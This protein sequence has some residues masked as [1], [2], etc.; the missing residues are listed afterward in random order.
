MADVL[1]YLLLQENNKLPLL[2]NAN[3]EKAGK[4]LN[5]MLEEVETEME[6]IQIEKDRVKRVNGITVG[7]KINDSRY[8]NEII[9]RSRFRKAL[10]N[11]HK[12]IG[13]GREASKPP[14][15]I[16]TLKQKKIADEFE[17]SASRD[18]RHSVESGSVSITEGQLKNHYNKLAAIKNFSQNLERSEGTIL[19]ELRECLAQ[20][21]EKHQN[22]I[23][24]L[25][26][27]KSNNDK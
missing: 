1:G 27:R 18:D 8:F 25:I 26:K 9:K 5:R 13:E 20:L 22:R 24:Y 4:G 21:T 12:T 19:P 23:I 7:E 2:N 11:T 16:Y 10:K 6:K 15:K 14:D 3:M 17:N